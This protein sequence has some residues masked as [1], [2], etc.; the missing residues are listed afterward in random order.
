M[1]ILE[2]YWSISDI[3]GLSLVCLIVA[4]F[5]FYGIY[6]LFYYLW[7]RIFNW[8]AYAII[9]TYNPQMLLDRKWGVRYKKHFWN[10]WRNYSDGIRKYSDD[11]LKSEAEEIERKIKSGEIKV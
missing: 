4:L 9:Y 7:N 8:K 2:I 10:R 6:K 11:Y 3:I 1:Y 5:L